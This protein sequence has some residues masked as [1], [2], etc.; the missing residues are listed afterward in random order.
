MREKYYSP[1][2]D[3]LPALSHTTLQAELI[4]Q[5]FDGQRKIYRLTQQTLSVAIV[6]KDN[7]LSVT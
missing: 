7:R 4:V 2:S 1:D 5:M 6:R 3:K